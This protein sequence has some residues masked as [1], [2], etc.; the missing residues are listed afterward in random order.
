QV[1]TGAR[2]ARQC[3]NT[4]GAWLVRRCCGNQQGIAVQVDARGAAEIPA[5]FVGSET[6]TPGVHGAIRPADHRDRE[7][8]PAAAAAKR[9]PPGDARALACPPFSSNL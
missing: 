3:T 9:H 5:S 2:F 7:S 1:K 8:R 6:V 4:A